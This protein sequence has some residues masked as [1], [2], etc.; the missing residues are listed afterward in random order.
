MTLGTFSEEKQNMEIANYT[1][2]MEEKVWNILKHA[3]AQTRT[4]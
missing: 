4:K 2:Q 3:E 1:E